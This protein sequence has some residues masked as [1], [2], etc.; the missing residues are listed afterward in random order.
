MMGVSIPAEKKSGDWHFAKV[1]Y[2][3]LL[4]LLFLMEFIIDKS[5]HL[6]S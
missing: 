2:A 5:Y 3:M 4:L 6:T 1:Q